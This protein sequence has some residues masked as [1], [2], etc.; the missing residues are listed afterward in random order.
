MT[1][2]QKEDMTGEDSERTCVGCRQ[3]CEPGEL[4][5]FVLYDGHLVH[6]V[7]GKAPGRGA[8]VMP[9]RECLERALKGGFQRS[10]KQGKFEAPALD[11]LVETMQHALQERLKQG[12]QVGVRA[13]HLAIGA[14]AVSEAMKAGGV[15]LVWVASQAGDS[16]RQKFLMNASRKEIAAV[17]DLDGHELGSWLGREF[18][19]VLGVKNRGR[20]A[21]MMRDL[22]NFRD[23]VAF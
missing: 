7:R 16:T 19:A 10:F 8:W 20:A 3:V 21:R 22:K 9:R 6:D 17:D 13:R 4:E 23:L 5:R 14:V 11:E 18:V 15:D 12:V 1:S 2:E